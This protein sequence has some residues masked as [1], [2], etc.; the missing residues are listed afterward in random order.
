MGERVIYSLPGV[1]DS[2]EHTG[3]I[4]LRAKGRTIL[5]L[6]EH[7]GVALFDQMVDISTVRALEERS[8][9]ASGFDL[10]SLLYRWLENLL[11]LYYSENFMC[12]EVLVEELRVAKTQEGEEYLLRGVC[13]GEVFDPEKHEPRVEIKSPTYSLMRI[14]K[15]AEEWAAYFVLDI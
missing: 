1:Y 12:S 5:E 2:L 15:T 6:F 10:E 4:Y 8:V 14:I 13:R 11:F 3:D 9:E 7:A